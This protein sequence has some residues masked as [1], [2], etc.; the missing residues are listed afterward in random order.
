MS[1]TTVTEEFRMVTI[2]ER[3][4]IQTGNKTNLKG[5]EDSK[6]IPHVFNF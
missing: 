6:W 5:I 4:D 3:E 1:N 2:K